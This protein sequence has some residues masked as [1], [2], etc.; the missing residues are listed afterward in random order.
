MVSKTTAE[1]ETPSIFMETEPEKSFWLADGRQLRTL[2]DLAEALKTMDDAVWEHHVAAE[3]NDF[4]NWAEDVFGQKALG[5]ALRKVKSPAT[6]AKRI[7][8]KLDSPKFWSF[9]F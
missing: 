8:A 2:K 6:A 9:L 3:K 5:A 4:A 7:A 1:K